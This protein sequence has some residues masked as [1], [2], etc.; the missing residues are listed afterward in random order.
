MSL[1]RFLSLFTLVP[2]NSN[3]TVNNNPYVFLICV[4]VCVSLHD[5]CS[6]LIEIS[7]KCLDKEENNSRAAEQYTYLLF[8]KNVSAL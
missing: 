4:C 7:E 5:V 8:T 6:Q 1:T 3:T 2:R